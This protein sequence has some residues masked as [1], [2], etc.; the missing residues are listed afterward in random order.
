MKRKKHPFFQK[1]KAM[2]YFLLVHLAISLVLVITQLVHG[3]I[4]KDP[5][6]SIAKPFE[7]LKALNNPEKY[8]KSDLFLVET[9]FTEQR[10]SSGVSTSHFTYTTIKGHLADSKIQ[11][12]ETF[13]NNH[14]SNV[15]PIKSAL[16]SNTTQIYKPIKVFVNKLNDEIYLEDKKLLQDE[17]LNAGL[18]FYFQVSLIV[19]SIQLLILKKRSEIK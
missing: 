7:N 3:C 11:R 18:G 1:N 16:T 12:Q 19:L 9:A 13:Q 2:K 4:E 10:K 14:L 15:Y 17:K 5:I 6:K 8:L